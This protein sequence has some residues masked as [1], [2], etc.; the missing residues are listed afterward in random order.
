V[1]CAVYL[2]GA[3]CSLD[4]H[5]ADTILLKYTLRP[6]LHTGSILASGGDGG[7]LLLWRPSAGGSAAFGADPA[8]PEP[9]WRAA[10]VLRRASPGLPVFNTMQRRQ[11]PSKGDVDLQLQAAVV[12]SE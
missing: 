12:A 5:P 10:T 6:S 8:I 3:S 4:T 11:R 9:A 2:Q 1:P 7:E